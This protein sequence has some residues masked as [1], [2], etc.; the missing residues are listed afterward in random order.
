MSQARP[1]TAGIGQVPAGLLASH[2]PPGASV[3]TGS[4][5]EGANL[6]LACHPAVV[7]PAARPGR[8]LLT[9]EP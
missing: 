4:S 5:D 9:F 2:R 7:E 3:R 1:R 8:L 6:G